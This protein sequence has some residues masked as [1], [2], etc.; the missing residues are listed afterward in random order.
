MIKKDKD[1]LRA[2]KTM[3]R[4][5]EDCKHRYFCTECAAYNGKTCRLKAGKQGVP[6]GWDITTADLQRLEARASNERCM[7]SQ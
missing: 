1:L 7:L 5:Q 2:V 4:F 6:A 3:Y